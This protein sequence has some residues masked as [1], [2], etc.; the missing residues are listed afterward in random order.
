[1]ETPGERAE[2]ISSTNAISAHWEQQNLASEG[3]HGKSAKSHERRSIPQEG[4]F[5]R[6][7]S[8]IATAG[9]RKVVRDG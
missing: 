1:M 2:Q 6:N 5:P 8:N 3:I 4:R 7:S 9:Q